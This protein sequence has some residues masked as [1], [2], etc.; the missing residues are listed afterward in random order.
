M[1][2]LE[3]LNATHDVVFAVRSLARTT[4]GMVTATFCGLHD[5]PWRKSCL[6]VAKNR[7]FRPVATLSEGAF[8]LCRG[9][10]RL[11]QRLETKKNI[12]LWTGGKPPYL[13]IVNQKQNSDRASKELFR[14]EAQRRKSKKNSQGSLT[15]W[16]T[17]KKSSRPQH[18][19]AGC[20]PQ[21]VGCP[22]WTAKGQK[23]TPQR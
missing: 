22:Y 11:S 23:N 21:S 14:A 13:C 8:W 20:L 2:F 10:G 15:Y 7:F 3:N 5:S 12:F 19:P 4:S 9:T 18:P 16:N 17:R 6:I 1:N